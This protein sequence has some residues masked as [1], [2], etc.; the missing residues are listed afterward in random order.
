[1]R[2][3]K[4]QDAEIMK[5]ALQQEIVRTEEARYDHRLHGVLLVCAGKSCYEVAGLLGHSPRT[6]QY[7]VERFE[8]SGFA[9]L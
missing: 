9:G 3:L 8:E 5:I 7:W 4:V 6:I 2:K 1:M